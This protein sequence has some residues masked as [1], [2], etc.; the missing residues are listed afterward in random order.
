MLVTIGKQSYEKMWSDFNKD[1]II[2]QPPKDAMSVRQ[3]ALKYKVSI[4]FAYS[5]LERAVI[6]G[7]VV[8]KK[9]RI[10]NHNNKSCDVKFYSLVKLRRQK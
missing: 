9:Y 8:C 6:K 4:H 7:E 10:I 3:Y 2:E 5:L 1:K